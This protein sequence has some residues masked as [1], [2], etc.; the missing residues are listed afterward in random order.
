[1]PDTMDIV[2]FIADSVS[3]V[4]LESI[5]E[6][7]HKKN[8]VDPLYNDSVCSQTLN[9]ICCYKEC[10]FWKIK[11]FCTYLNE[12][13]YNF[14]TVMYPVKKKYFCTNFDF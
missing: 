9:W 13:V 7:C 2:V 1:M 11:P 12:V 5:A 3:S 6:N 8:I 14:A 4:K 10:I